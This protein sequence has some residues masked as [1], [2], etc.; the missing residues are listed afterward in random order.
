[1]KKIIY[2]GL[3]VVFFLGTI[4]LLSST[5]IKQGSKICEEL[6]IKI[7]TKSGMHFISKDD[8]ILHLRKVNMSPVGKPMSEISI[9][10]L[11]E[12]IASIPEI[13]NAEVYTTIDGKIGIEIEQRVPV[14]RVISN[15]GNSFYIDEE[16]YQME[17]SE[18]YFPRL[19]VVTGY[20]N[21]GTTD[22]SA[23]RIALDPVKSK[24]FKMDEIFKLVRFI[25]KDKF[26]QAQIQQIDITRKGEIEL[27]PTAGDHR[28][29]F[30]TLDNMEGKFNKLF[31]FYKE[32]LSNAGWEFYKTV[33]VKYKHQI[34]CTKK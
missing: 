19:L 26:W 33:N 2:I 15:N 34:I 16:G 3:W 5:K 25:N 17:V 8:I 13:K 30:G 20:V 11:E 6:L 27:I 24:T 22:L 4:T 14:V 31:V 1:M 7:D 23:R 18:K 10:D 9:K 12:T 21:D 32:G 28:I 29:I